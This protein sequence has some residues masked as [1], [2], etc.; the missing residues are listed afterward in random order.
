MKSQLKTASPF[1]CLDSTKTGVGPLSFE[2]S[3][4]EPPPLLS[5]TMVCFKPPWTWYPEIRHWW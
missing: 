5:L 3:P 1:L 2:L 4:W